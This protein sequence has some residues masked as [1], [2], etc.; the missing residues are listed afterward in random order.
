MLLARARCNSNAIDRLHFKS[1]AEA[2]KQLK[3]PL[4]HQCWCNKRLEASEVKIAGHSS[5]ALLALH[6]ALLRSLQ[7][8]AW[9][10]GLRLSTLC[11]NNTSRMIANLQQA[12]GTF[13]ECQ[14]DTTS[15]LM[16]LECW[17][18]IPADIGLFLL[19]WYHYLHMVA[20]SRWRK[21]PLGAYTALGRGNSRC[22]YC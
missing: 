21:H 10:A 19:P 22:T 16:L 9:L 11:I 5:P 3:S 18:V 13:V 1:V 12:V 17:A 15:I 7:K 8:L 6:A 14:G 4:T 2:T 20:H